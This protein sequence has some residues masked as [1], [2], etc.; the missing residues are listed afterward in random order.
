MKEESLAGYRR[1]LKAG[2][3][4]VDAVWSWVDKMIER[5]E[6]GV[7]IAR[8][9]VADDGAFGSDMLTWLQSCGVRFGSSRASF[10]SYVSALEQILSGHA[11]EP[12]T[13]AAKFP[14]FRPRISGEEHMSR[15][16]ACRE[17]IRQGE[18]YELNQT[19]SF[20]ATADSGAYETYLR[21][22]SFNPAYYSTF[23]SFPCIPTPKGQGL[24]VLSSSPE[25]FLQIRDG[26][27]EM[28]PIKGT[29]KRVHPGQ[30]VCVP[31]VGCSGQDK[32]NEA[33]LAEAAREDEARGKALSEDLK[34]RAENLMVS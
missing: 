18:S 3:V 10:D 33:C 22:R 13:P 5:T 31:G 8:G 1:P 27:I 12:A 30:C 14:T 17:A 7:W 34:E 25:R 6:D 9:V 4:R 32:G 16:D 20:I 23:I 15:I 24:H 2:G 28:R 19:T 21:L 11:V 26:E 29:S